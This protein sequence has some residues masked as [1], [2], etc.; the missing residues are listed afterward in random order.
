MGQI[1][2][3]HFNSLL[4]CFRCEKYSSAES[5]GEEICLIT[6]LVLTL[7]TYVTDNVIPS[8]HI[9]CGH[10]SSK[11]GSCIYPVG[12]MQNRCFFG[13][14]S[15]ASASLEDFVSVVGGISLTR[16]SEES[17]TASQKTNAAMLSSFIKWRMTFAIH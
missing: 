14:K 5:W 10:L 12:C 7:G 2:D 8:G 1:L 15:S 6:E 16:A 11:M 13:N 9:R 17:S 4:I 3:V